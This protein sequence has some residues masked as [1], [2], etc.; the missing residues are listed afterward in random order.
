M[1]KQSFAVFIFVIFCLSLSIG[2]AL[3][4]ETVVINGTS[5]ARGTFDIIFDNAQVKTEVGS[6]GA[7]A[8]ISSDKNTL[9]LA[10]PKLEY[11]GAYVEF[12]VDVK[13]DGSIPAILTG[14]TESG[15]TTDPNIRVSY[16]GIARNDQMNQSDVKPITIKVEWLYESETSSKDIEFSIK[17]DFRQTTS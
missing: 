13:N 2:Y 5:N 7:S 9:T 16:S 17:L 14:I 8:I 10:V 15:L 3:F 6:T 4:S 1:K 11:P 12:T